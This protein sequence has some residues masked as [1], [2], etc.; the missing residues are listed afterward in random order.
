M[1]FMRA[2]Q[3]IITLFYKTDVISEQVVIHMFFKK[4]SPVFKVIFLVLGDS[5]MVQS[6]LQR[7][8]QDDVC[9]P[10]EGVCGVAAK[11]RRRE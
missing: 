2:F 9:R 1:T 7:Q 3:K 10:D 4:R 6:G 5:E 8:R 11:R